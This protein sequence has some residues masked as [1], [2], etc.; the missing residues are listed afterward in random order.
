MPKP[1]G[2][3]I[4]IKADEKIASQA[5]EAK[6]AVATSADKDRARFL[7]LLDKTSGADLSAWHK[8]MGA[9]AAAIKKNE[10]LAKE[11]KVR[12]AVS[13]VLGEVRKLLT[14]V[15]DFKAL[16]SAL[17]QPATAVIRAP[18]NLGMAGAELALVIALV[19]VLEILVRIRTSARKS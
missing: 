9:L 12:K 5:V 15:K 13:D 18:Q 11:D 14:E 16:D 6:K 8:A 3:Y 19:K 1:Q 7:D 2:T 4:R 17:Q 10:P